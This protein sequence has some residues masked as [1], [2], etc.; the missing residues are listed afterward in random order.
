MATFRPNH[1]GI[2]AMESAPWMVE[3]MRRKADQARAYAEIIAPVDTG[4]YRASFFVTA[5]TRGGKAYARLNNN[6]RDPRTGYPYCVAL[7]FGNSRIKAQR[8]IQRSIDALR[9]T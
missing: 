1:A 9:A 7:E 6:A 4:H 5:G 3:A 8:I 2:R